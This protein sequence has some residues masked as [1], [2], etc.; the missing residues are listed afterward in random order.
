MKPLIVLCSLLCAL[1]VRQVTVAQPAT[2][3][4]YLWSRDGSRLVLVVQNDTTLIA[5][6]Y[7]DQWQPL[8]SRQITCC[9]GIIIS[10]DGK[11]LMVNSSPAEIWDTDTLTTVRVLPEFMGV[12]Y[13]SLDGTEFVAGSRE[14]LGG[15][16][17]Y[18]AA[19][20]RLLREFTPTNSNAWGWPYAPVRSPNGT[21][22][23]AGLSNQLVFLDPITGQQIGATYQ[24]DGSIEQFRWST[25]GT[26]LA[27]SLRKEVSTQIEGSFPTG[28]LGGSYALN[29]IVVFKVS[30]GTITTLRSGFRQPA[31]TLVWSPD[32]RY[33][34]TNLDR[35]LYTMDAANGNLIES[36]NVSSGFTVI[37]WS[38][39]GGRLLTGLGTNA[40]YDPVIYGT[41]ANYPVCVQR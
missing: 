41:P 11:S 17:I 29:S 26:R 12:P 5:T 14:L 32:D 35:N 16:K 33:I 39:N 23:A 10:P 18:N 7:D 22:Y 37:G 8:A 40:V 27:I 4:S 13:W 20:Y 34:I 25:D 31:F 21:Y 9:G 3:Y 19:D 1:F 30:T 28:N 6:V 36:L 24:L 15:I 38:P 2:F